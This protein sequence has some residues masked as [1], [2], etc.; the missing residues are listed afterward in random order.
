MRNPI[1]LIFGT[2]LINSKKVISKTIVFKNLKSYRDFLFIK[3][4]KGYE[5]TIDIYEKGYKTA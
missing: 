2:I 1:W 5:L 3:C 4:A